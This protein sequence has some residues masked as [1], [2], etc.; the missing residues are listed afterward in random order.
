M[1]LVTRLGARSRE[2][3]LNGSTVVEILLGREGREE[4]REGRVKGGRE[5]RREGGRGER[6][7]GG[8]E[9]G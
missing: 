7:E 9:G 3:S 4:R 5:G 6:R 8:R 1:R 2:M